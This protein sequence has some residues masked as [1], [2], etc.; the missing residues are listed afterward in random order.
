MMCVCVWLGADEAGYALAHVIY[1]YPSISME[2]QHIHKR[3][4]GNGVERTFLSFRI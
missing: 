4:V 1:C 2:L 3:L